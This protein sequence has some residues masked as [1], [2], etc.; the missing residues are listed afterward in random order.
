MDIRDPDIKDIADAERDKMAHLNHEHIVAYK[1]CFIDHGFMWLIMEYCSG[2]DLADE[3]EINK[4]KKTLF[5]EDQ[6][7]LWTFQICL[8]LEVLE[9]N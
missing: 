7:Q 8:G 1:E 5:T 2:G 9:S 3:I 6:I 4:R